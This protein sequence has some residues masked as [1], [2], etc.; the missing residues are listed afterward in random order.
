MEILIERRAAAALPSLG[1]SKANS[2]TIVQQGIVV[3]AGFGSVSAIEYLKAHNID[4]KVISR[5]LTGG[6]VPCDDNTALA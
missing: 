2:T 3:Q 4:S 6:Q 1:F 5:V